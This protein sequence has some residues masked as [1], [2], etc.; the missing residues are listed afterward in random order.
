MLKYILFILIIFT[1]IAVFAQTIKTDVVVISGTYSGTAAALQCAR[2][3]VKTV[4]IESGNYLGVPA[5]GNFAINENTILASGI[6]GEFR[7]K[8]TAY[9]SKTKGYDTTA[10]ASLKLTADVANTVLRQLTDTVKN[11]TIHFN[12]S[13]TAI[14]KNG[15]Y[16]NVS[17]TTNGHTETVKA[18]VL[19]D[20]TPNSE[21]A[22]KAG[23][24]FTTDADHPDST[25]RQL[26]GWVHAGVDDVYTPYINNKLYRTAIA[27]NDGRL[28]NGKLL[29]AF[30]LPLGAVVAKNVENVL[31]AGPHVSAAY[32]INRALDNAS[33]QLILGQGVG[34][35]AAFCAFYETTTRNLNVRSIQGELLDFKG[36]LLPFS[37]IAATDPDRRSIHQVS[38][39]GLLQGLQVTQGKATEMHFEPGAPVNTAEI[40]PVLMELYTRSFLWFNRVK[41][42]QQFTVANM[43]S[44]MSE[45]TLTDPKV[46]ES[47]IQRQWQLAYHFTAPFAISRPITRREFAVLANQYLNPFARRVDLAGNMIN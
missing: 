42:G 45:F 36:Y 37:D 40:K 46:M 7:K 43:L 15:D 17:I 4:L 10:A 30:A 39:T 9:Y 38:A 11:L 12:T 29:P 1:K 32:A 6:W 35:I 47:R 18:R 41:P 44:L 28:S 5:W 21:A 22:I 31:V 19:I 3:K 20:A 23:A 24:V 34:T 25:G 27:V 14:K 16:W 2:S 26:I 13:W 8:V 33:A